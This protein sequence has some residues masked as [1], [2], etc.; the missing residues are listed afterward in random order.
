MRAFKTG[1]VATVFFWGGFGMF[2]FTM[3]LVVAH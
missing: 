2:L 1:L 3:R